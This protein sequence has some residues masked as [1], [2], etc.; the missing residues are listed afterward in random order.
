MLSHGVGVS[1]S[2]TVCVCGFSIFKIESSIS[3][4]NIFLSDNVLQ[5]LQTFKTQENAQ[6]RQI[7][8]IIVNV[9]LLS[10]IDKRK[11]TSESGAAYVIHFL[12]LAGLSVVFP[13]GNQTFHFTKN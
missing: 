8:N 1:R 10:D 4:S 2:S 13:P 12:F 11:A 5:K 6:L 9:A 3:I 7:N